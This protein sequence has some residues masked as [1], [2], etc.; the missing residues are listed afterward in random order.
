MAELFLFNVH[1]P[2]WHLAYFVP[3]DGHFGQMFWDMDFTFILP[4][5]YINFNIQTNF[6]VN[7]TQISYIIPKNLKSP[8]CPSAIHKKAQTPKK[9]HARNQTRGT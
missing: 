1:A 3:I 4:I 2:K 6:E 8:F 9:T 5:I 7:R